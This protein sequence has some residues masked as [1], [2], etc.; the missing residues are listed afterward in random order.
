MQFYM[1]MQWVCFLYVHAV[2]MLNNTL[3]CI[4]LET[5]INKRCN[6]TNNFLLREK[7]CF[8]KSTCIYKIDFGTFMKGYIK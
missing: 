7:Q 1:F 8:Y 2:G 5:K 4:K 6:K 3:Y